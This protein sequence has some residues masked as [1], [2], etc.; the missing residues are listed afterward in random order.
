MI[1]DNPWKTP[2]GRILIGSS[3]VAAVVGFSV[4]A[5][6][7]TYFKT[8]ASA[9]DAPADAVALNTNEPTRWSEVEAPAS[10]QRDVTTDPEGYAAALAALE[11]VT[12]APEPP[13]G[14]SLEVGEQGVPSEGVIIE[15]QIAPEPDDGSQ[16]PSADLG[17]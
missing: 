4:A 12:E 14:E 5:G 8:E 17:Q 2:F 15:E 6:L 3:I 10:T 9:P 13:T 1:E 7:T 11:P 16:A